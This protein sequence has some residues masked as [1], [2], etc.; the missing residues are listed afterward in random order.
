MW[1]FLVTDAMGFAGLLLAYA[2]LRVRAGSWPDP[3]ERFDRSLAGALTFVLLFSG[4]TMTAAV[5]AAREG[6]L[7]AARLL[8]ALTALAGLAFVAGQVAEFHAL[9]TARHLGLTADHAAALFYVITGYHGL[10]VLIGVVV[11][12]VVA[13]RRAMKVGVVEV[14]SLY[15]QFVD[16]LWIVIFAAL[17]LLPPVARG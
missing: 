5:A 6:K 8:T 2:I 3:G 7:G 15:W 16:V 17:Y 12:T 14:V 1:V 9:S 13:S 4:A 11:L 10:H